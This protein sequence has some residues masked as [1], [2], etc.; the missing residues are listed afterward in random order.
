M[1]DLKEKILNES[2]NQKSKF[3]IKDLKEALDYYEEYYKEFPEEKGE[4]PNW[5]ELDNFFSNE[6]WCEALMAGGSKDDD[7][8]VIIVDKIFNALY[9]K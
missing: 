7:P 8:L 4:Y 9:S 3:T 1:K 6:D 5:G 2:N